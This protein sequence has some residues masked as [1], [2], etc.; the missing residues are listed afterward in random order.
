MGIKVVYLHIVY[1]EDNDYS[2]VLL[3]Q[4]IKESLFEVVCLPCDDYEL[5]MDTTD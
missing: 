3:R 4:R 2:H 1:D 5:V